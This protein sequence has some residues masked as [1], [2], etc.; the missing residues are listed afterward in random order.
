MYLNFL[1]IFLTNIFLFTSFTF[2]DENLSVYELPNSLTNVEGNEK[3]GR[4]I[5]LSRQGNCI[6]CHKIPGVEDIFQG[7]I[8]PSLAGVGNRYTIAELRL[9]LVDPYVI[10]S[11]TVMPAYYKKKG[12]IRVEKKYINQSILSEQQIEDV[13]SWLATLKD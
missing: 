2:S 4:I 6:A 9:R 11:D 5:V 3:N 8:G 12:L 13:I 10:N 1:V 7:N